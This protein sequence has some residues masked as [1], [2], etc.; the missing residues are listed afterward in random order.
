MGLRR[1]NRLRGGSFLWNTCVFLPDD[2]VIF[3]ETSHFIF[4]DAPSPL[5]FPF[6][7]S[8]VLLFHPPVFL[9]FCAFDRTIFDNHQLEDRPC[10]T[11]TPW[12]V[13]PTGKGRA[14]PGQALRVPGGWGSHIEGSQRMKVVRLSALST[15]CLYPQE[16]FLVLLSVRPPGP[17]SGRR[18]LNP[19]T[20]G[21]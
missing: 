9:P 13:K 1:R 12:H 19:R 18:K 8:T 21:L 5:P 7:R 11:W 3:Q 4:R 10:L 6:I 15:G 17:K 14:I 20:S 2:K 16:I